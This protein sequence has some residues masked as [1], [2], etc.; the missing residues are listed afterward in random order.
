MN[1]AYFFKLASTRRYHVRFFKLGKFSAN[2][3]YS[4]RD[5]SFFLG[6]LKFITKSHT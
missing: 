2:T 6:K 1:H 4:E 5:S 3:F